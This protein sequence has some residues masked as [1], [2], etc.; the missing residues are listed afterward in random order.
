V[1]ENEREYL[2][3][4]M[5]QVETLANRIND[6]RSTLAELKMSDGT[7]TSRLLAIPWIGQNTASTD[8]DYSNS[9]C[10]PACLA[11]WLTW[12]DQDHIITVDDVSA[13]T[14]LPLG[15]KYTIPANLITAAAHWQL[16]LE[17]V[18]NFSFDM[19]RGEINRGSPALVLVHYPDLVK[20][21]DVKY[22]ASHWILVIGYDE[23][24]L[25][26]NDPYW[27][28]NRGAAIHIEYAAFALA[29]RDVALDG[30]TANQGLRQAA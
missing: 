23:T 30:N 17:R 8:D 19:I 11:M 21:F 15:Y 6:L 24:G 3:L 27:P 10:G 25:I 12:H 20:R 16:K 2:Q 1:N 29:M 13:A 28:D 5:L 14:G 18:L 9:D 7:K 4:A 22:K 26:Y